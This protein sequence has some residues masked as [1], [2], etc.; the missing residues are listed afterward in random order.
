MAAAAAARAGAKGLSKGASRLSGA[1]SAA[2]GGNTGAALL[3][4]GTLM[5]GWLYV[6]GRLPKVWEAVN[7]PV[8]P[9][10]SMGGA[11]DPTMSRQFETVPR[12]APAGRLPPGSP[13]VLPNPP[14]DRGEQDSTYRSFT[15]YPRPPKKGPPVQVLVDIRKPDE[16]ERIII[17]VL[18]ELGYPPAER[19]AIASANC[20]ARIPGV[21]M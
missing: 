18:T 9:M 15:F 17:E 7:G 21:W 10:M 6:T 13:P 2:T 14:N 11:L 20:R 1:A 16:C 4:F 8:F 3:V 12:D 5:L 19:S